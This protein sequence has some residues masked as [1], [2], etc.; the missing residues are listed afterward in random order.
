MPSI[1]FVSMVNTPSALLAA[2]LINEES[3]FESRQTFANSR[4]APCVSTT[5]PLIL[6]IIRYD[7][8]KY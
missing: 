7:G 8:A 3:A 2:P 4:G 1:L 6:Y 5:F